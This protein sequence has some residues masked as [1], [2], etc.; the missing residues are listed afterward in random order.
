MSTVQENLLRTFADSFETGT[1]TSNNKVFYRL[2]PDAPDWIDMRAIHAAVDGKG[3]R[4]PDDW[5][6]EHTYRVATSLTEYDDP[7]ENVSEVADGLVDV[8]NHERAA[9]LA[10]S[11][12][13]NGALVDEAVEEMHMPK[14]ATIY[15]RIAG[16][17]MLA[18]ERIAYAVLE[19]C[20]NAADDEE[21]GES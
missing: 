18:L 1:R 19:Q 2:S 5:I 8:Y 12:L 3:V 14:D 10:A 21:D 11:H 17:Q 13:A 15:E 6:Y 4:M 7:E 9:W 20:Q 16:G